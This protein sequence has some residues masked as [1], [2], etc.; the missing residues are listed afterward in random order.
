MRQAVIIESTFRSV[1]Q[2]GSEI[3]PW[4]PVKLLSRNRFDNEARIAQVTAPI[5]VAHSPDD[6]IIPYAHGRALFEAANDPKAFLEFRGDHNEGFW[7]SG[8]AYKKGLDEFLREHL[9]GR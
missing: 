3:Y 5:L 1:P 8:D 6:T 9:A 7:T 4:L 2:F